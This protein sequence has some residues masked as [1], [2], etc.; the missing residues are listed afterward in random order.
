MGSDSTSSAEWSLIDSPEAWDRFL[1]EVSDFHD[2]IVKEIR[3]SHDGYVLV[4]FSMSMPE[5]AAVTLLI[6][7]QWDQLP[8][9]ELRFEEVRFVRFDTRDEWVDHK[10]EPH[11]GGGFVFRFL[12]CEIAAK[13]AR[14]RP[15][16][17]SYLGPEP[18][19]WDSH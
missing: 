1:D 13:L 4:D 12:E 10:A 5:T 17:S 16:D 3:I 8:A 6:Q 18:A 9:A 11:E 19:G 14:Y 2:G 7:T 15:L